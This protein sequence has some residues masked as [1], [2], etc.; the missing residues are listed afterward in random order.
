M[1]TYTRSDIKTSVSSMISG[2]ISDTDL[3]TIINRAARQVVG[4]IDMHSRIRRTSL[5]PNLFDDIYDY[6]APTDL[7]M[8]GIIDIQP[9]IKR[10]R[11][12]SW[13]LT[14]PEEFDRLKGES[15]EYGLCAISEK[16]M[17]KTIK[18]SKT[19][20]DTSITVDPLSSVGDWEG[21][22][23]GE[24]LTKDSSN[25]VKSVAS[26]NWDIN[27]D[28]N[29]TAGI[30][31]NELTTFD[32]SDYLSNGSIFVWAYI[33]STTNLTNFKIRIGSSSSNYYEIT[34]TANNEEASFESG[35]NLLRFDLSD[36]VETGTV[37]Y[38]DCTYCAIFM[39]KD[40]LKTDE[41]D[42]RFNYLVIK[43][44]ERYNLVYYSKY[45]WQDSDGD[46]LENSSDDTDYINV[47]TEEMSLIE[48]KAAELGERHLRNHKEA[49]E[50]A[51]LYEA[52]KAN[53]II[54]NPSQAIVM[55]TTYHFT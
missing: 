33:S 47:D 38:E 17:A 29:T 18:I 10:T 14:S 42:Y 8:N 5:S 30:Y 6:S 28:G 35:W 26:I 32:L 2:T 51:N 24:N 12:E 50:N 1:A 49:I 3:N 9:Q 13:E 48:L 46:Y 22:G 21:Y 54:N 52:E 4:G 40:A 43:M 55:T 41:T 15:N 7:K 19:I 45:A 34:I 20:D 39:T 11:N 36:K 31:N 27:D 37:D 25:Y 44:G 16:G 53:Y 23:D